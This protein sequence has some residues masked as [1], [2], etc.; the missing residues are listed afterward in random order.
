MDFQRPVIELARM[1][2][3]SRSKHIVLLGIGHTNAHV[4][5]MW[6]MN[7]IPDCDLTCISDNAVATYSG[8]LPAV[9]AGQIP[10][11][12]M[13]LVVKKRVGICDAAPA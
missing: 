2:E 9:L 8:M 5:R 7:P 1:M 12:E 3:R 4:V 13:L 11:A 6:G 10:K